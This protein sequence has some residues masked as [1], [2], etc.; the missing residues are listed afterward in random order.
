M[1]GYFPELKSIRA[2]AKVKLDLSNS[3]TKLDFKDA[4]GVVTSKFGKKVDLANL[5][6]NLGKLDIDKLKAVSF[7]LNNL[8]R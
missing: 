3:A 7:N 1:S 8:K 5:K 6:F 4:T 2:R